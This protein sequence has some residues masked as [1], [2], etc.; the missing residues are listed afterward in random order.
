VHSY[1]RR[2]ED[3][4]Q[5]GAHIFTATS[6]AI[7]LLCIPALAEEKISLQDRGK[8]AIGIPLPSDGF[9]INIWRVGEKTMFGVEVEALGLSNT[10]RNFNDESVKD[11][12]NTGINITSALTLKRFRPMRWE[13]SPFSYQTLYGDIRYANISAKGKSTTWI[14]GA[15][16]GLGVVWFPFKRVSL[17]LRQG[18]ALEIKRNRVD[19]DPFFSPESHSN[20]NTFAF[21]APP[22]RLLALFHF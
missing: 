8:N 11:S 18:F 4:M 6:L 20:A 19:P 12:E 16:L 1:I 17:S 3:E 21:T 14:A 13:L 10:R 7:V 5:N 9:S 15:G 2:G 22:M